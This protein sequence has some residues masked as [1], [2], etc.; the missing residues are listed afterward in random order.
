[1]GTFI[2]QRL[3][4]NV[5]ILLVVTVLIFTLLQ[6]TPGDPLDSYL[7]PDQVVTAEFK[8][9]LRQQLGL[10][11]PPVLRYGFWLRAALTGNLGYRSKNSEPVLEAI[12]LR[13]GPTVLLMASGMGL[14]IA[15]GLLFGIVAAVRRYS[16]LDNALTFLAFLGISTPA[17]LAGL[18]GL[19]VFS[20]RWRLFP[21][22]GYSTP[23]L[24]VS[25]PDVL[26]HLALPA[27][28]LSTFYVAI[29]MRYTRAAMLETIDQD[30]VRTARAKGLLERDVIGKHALRNALI[31]VVTVIG[32]NLGN[33]VGGAVFLE[34]IFG[35][36]GMGQ[37]YLDGVE[38]RDYPLIMGLT[39]VLSSAVLMANLLT[40]MAYAA[41]D[42]RIRYG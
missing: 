23:G 10:D 6:F 4:L 40:D 14:G 20:L 39:L 1:M 33:L 8:E 19:Y 24:E 25:A 28:L 12:R 29:I 37:L 42:P 9:S 34:S 26:Y 18:I 38:S 2:L 3:A 22:G 21:T 11:Q 5:P 41:I 17:F 32:A 31:P 16:L 30:Y 35:W 7:P 36:P 13:V 27:L 15:L